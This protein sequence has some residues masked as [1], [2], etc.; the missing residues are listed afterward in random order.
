V[1]KINRALLEPLLRF[2]LDLAEERLQLPLF[3]PGI[4]PLIDRQY[5]AMVFTHC[6]LIWDLKIS[7]DTLSKFVSAKE[8]HGDR[9]RSSTI[10]TSRRR[11]EKG[12]RD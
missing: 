12:L 7:A 10:K 11:K 6:L 3:S 4:G 2:R 8:L 1:R 9:K 5:E